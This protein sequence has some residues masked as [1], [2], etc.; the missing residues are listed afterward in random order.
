MAPM[1]DMVNHTDISPCDVDLFHTK[2]HT[3]NNQIYNHRYEPELDYTDEDQP[4]FTFEEKSHRMMY[5]VKHIYQQNNL[6]ADEKQISGSQPAEIE[7]YNERAVFERF[8]EL[9]EFE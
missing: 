8:K 3:A 6:K 9:Y 4:K 1:I 5:N 7:P 2:L